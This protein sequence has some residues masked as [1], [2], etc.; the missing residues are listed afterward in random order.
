MQK[1]KGL[2]IYLLGKSPFEF[3][4]IDTFIDL[5]E[6]QSVAG[7]DV[8]IVMLHG[9]VLMARKDNKFEERLRKLAGAGVKIYVRKE[10]LDARGIGEGSTTDIGTAVTT[11]EIMDLAAKSSTLVSVI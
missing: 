6:R 2:I 11:L 3:R 8:A 10:D 4:S 5:A 7:T 1:V 9:A